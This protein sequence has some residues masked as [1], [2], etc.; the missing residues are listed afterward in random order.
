M[1]SFAD[2]NVY[3]KKLAEPAGLGHPADKC[4]GLDTNMKLGKQNSEANIFQ[5]QQFKMV[6]CRCNTPKS[7]TPHEMPTYIHEDDINHFY[8]DGVDKPVQ[9]YMAEKPGF[10]YRAIHNTFSVNT[11][12]Q[13]QITSS[14]TSGTMLSTENDVASLSENQNT[15]FPQNLMDSILEDPGDANHCKIKRD[16]Q[17]KIKQKI[18]N[19]QVYEL[20]SRHHPYQNDQH[21]LPNLPEFEN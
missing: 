8:A 9:C 14:H 7:L 2:T 3:P 4:G 6:N 12:C 18:T 5:T 15:S 20:Y 19:S 13:S 10:E 1:H 17:L 21:L 16:L 11:T